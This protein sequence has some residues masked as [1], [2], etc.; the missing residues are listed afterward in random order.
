MAGWPPDSP[1]G[2]SRRGPGRRRGDRGPRPSR[3]ALAGLAAGLAGLA[4]S[5]A[6]LVI[7]VLP[8]T[9]SPAQQHQITA[10]EISGRWRAWPAGR[11]FPPAVRYQLPGSVLAATAGLELTAQRA[12]IGP[13]ASCRAA[14]DPAVARVLATHSC[15]AVLRATYGDATQS[16]A[17]TVGVVVFPDAA[18]EQAAARALP[19]GVLPGGMMFTPGVRAVRF[20]GTTAAVFGPAQ[21]QLSWAS[22]QGPYLIMAAAG[23]AD[24]RPR[25]R[26]S[27]DP[28]ATAE[29]RSLAEGVA[30]RVGAALTAPPPPPHCPGAP[31]C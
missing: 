3:L 7:Q 25:V 9:F 13:Q 24:G 5:V 10:W 16:M 29:M 20:R 27:A 28:Y 30:G 4:V 17:V 26:E 18:A 14:T 1:F 8:R 22:S 2:E 21:R 12:G 15:L 31:G 6:G 19:A 23:Y 11:I